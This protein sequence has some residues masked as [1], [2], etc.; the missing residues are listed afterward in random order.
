M[1]MTLVAALVSIAP[2]G[3]TLQAGGATAGEPARKPNI[4]LIYGDDVGYGDLGCYG[5]TRISTPNLDALAREGVRFTAAYATAATCTPSR[6]SLLTGRY[7]FRKK[8]AAILSGAAPLVI[9]PDRPTLA[10]VLQ[11]AG[12]A[13]ACVGKWHLGL[14][15]GDVNWN[16][17]VAPGPLELGFDDSF[18]MPATNDRVPTVYIDDHRVHNLA[19]ADAPLR[20][21]YQEKIGNLPT[22]RSHPDQLR[23]PADAQHSGTI[24]DGISRIGWMTGGQSAW[25][26][27]GEIAATFVDQ[28]RQ[29]IHA[30]RDQRFFLYLPLRDVHVPRWP[31]E[32]F[33]G[34]SESG[35]RGDAMEEADWVVGRIVAT[36]REFDLT[37]QTLVIFTSD[38]GPVYTDG[39]QDGA[40]QHANG[41]DA[42][43]PWRGGKY[44]S[45]EGG[46]RVPFIVRWPGKTESG[47]TSEAL[48]SQVDLLA[49]LAKLA[50]AEVPTDA[51][52]DSV[53][54]PQVLLGRRKSGRPYLVQQGISKL[55][56]RYGPWKYI[57]TGAYA[58]WTF[59]KH[60]TPPSPIATSQP[61]ADQAMLFNLTDDPNESNNVIDAHPDIAD[62]MASMLNRLK[63]KPDPP[64][65][66][67]GR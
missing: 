48:L 50:G 43:G 42:N 40:I 35:L 34:G 53:A 3:G 67:Q 49:S 28:A 64:A 32:Q 5:A 18:I 37:Q 47:T 29:F 39:Y 45:F 17:R 38:N 54:M 59:T 61:A 27:E 52:P 24:V 14:G 10:S 1:L 19:E 56:L 33:R 13:T 62:N 2:A 11:Q 58:D 22:G 16:Q 26:E 63:R 21:S 65:Y 9:N 8:G 51:A 7:A 25:W 36:L 31:A 12:Y 30:N 4:V 57:P 41:H 46:T 20:V 23:Y 15:D 44:L 6:Y 60:N 55:A 66:P